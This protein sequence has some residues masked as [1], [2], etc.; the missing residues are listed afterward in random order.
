M[1]NKTFIPALQARVGDWNY[2]ICTMKYAEVAR[3][4]SFAYELGGNRD[5][6]SM[7]Q[8]GISDRTNDIVKYLINNDHRFLGALIVACWGGDPEYVELKMADPEGILEGVDRDFGV[9]TFDGTQQYFAL[10]GQHRLRAI[11]DAIK[12]DPEIGSEDIAVLIVSHYETDEGKERTRRLFTNINRNA[13]VTSAAENIALDED[14]GY[15]VM[16]RRLLTDHPFLSTDGVVKVFTSI[17]QEGEMRLAGNSVAATDKRAWSTIVVLR[18]LVDQLWYPSDGPKLL[19]R[20]SAEVVD[21]AYDTIVGRLDLLLKSCGDVVGQLTNAASARDVRA[22]KGKEEFGHPMFRPVI[23]RAVVR[24]V[25]SIVTQGE[26]TEA[27]VFERLSQLDWHIG[28][29]PWSA[30][31]SSEKHGMIAGKDFSALLVELLY[32]HLAPAST[33][34]VKRARRQFKTLRGM[35]YPVQEA[36]LVARV[37]PESGDAVVSALPTEDLSEDDA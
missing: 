13:K 18:D 30:V 20:P 27:E 23:Q 15:S 2:Y 24:V 11:K 31:Y 6:N 36:T 10:D 7:I 32:A 26:L 12:Q 21:G 34:A 4:V 9:L 5:L 14:D 25:R 35:N 1:A 19:D 33:Q 29:A 16:T 8:R 17:G 37:N 22:P 3:Q 28:E